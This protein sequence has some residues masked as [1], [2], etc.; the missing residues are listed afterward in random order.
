MPIDIGAVFF[1][2]TRRSTDDN[3]TSHYSIASV[4]ISG[5]PNSMKAVGQTASLLAIVRY[6]N[7]RSA[8]AGNGSNEEKVTW[9]SLAKGNNIIK[10]TDK[11]VIT[12]VGEGTAYIVVTTN[13]AKEDGT[14]AS[15][16]QAVKV[17][18][19]AWLN[20]APEFFDDW[21]SFNKELY[22]YDMSSHITAEANTSVISSAGFQSAF[23]NKWNADA[24]LIKDMTELYPKFSVKKV[25]EYKA[26][27]TQFF[28]AAMSQRPGVNVSMQES[29]EG[30]LLP[31]TYLWNNITAE[32]IKSLLGEDYQL[33]NVSET[34][35]TDLFTKMSINFT[36]ESNKNINVVRADNAKDLYNSKAL[37]ITKSD[38]KDSYSIELTA[39]LAHV[40]YS[41]KDSEPQLVN[42]LLIVPDNSESDNLTGTIWL[43][44]SASKGNEENDDNDD[45][46]SSGGGSGGGGGGCDSLALGI[47]AAGL[48]FALRRR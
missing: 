19:T 37:A 20:L 3:E 28:A 30:N 41:G 21:N 27:S 33:G 9:E 31:V 5:I 17:D 12:S 32:D 13:R 34:L 40:K 8:Y 4:R 18:K 14:Y 16:R 2:G 39:Y 38:S 7:G 42:N 47:F 11:G 35:A 29:E 1:D 36:T 43:V 25:S 10:I 46:S 23:K 6:T 24:S 48:L 15:D 22:E 44:P 45:N 26:S